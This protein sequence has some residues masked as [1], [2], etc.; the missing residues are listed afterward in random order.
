[1]PDARTRSSL[2]PLALFTVLLLAA[3]PD[4]AATS[5]GGSAAGPG[6]GP[7]PGEGPGAPAEGGQP[8]PA[9]PTQDWSD[10]D[11]DA[12]TLSGTTSY[13]GTKEGKIRLDFLGA[14]SIGGL[15]IG[16]MNALA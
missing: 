2:A 15:W 4:P 14:G 16:N 7:A 6:A 8:G 3:C 9:G 5:R 13:A 11:G 1:M 12:V 10:I